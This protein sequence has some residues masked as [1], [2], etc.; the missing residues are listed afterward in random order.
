MTNL[1]NNYKNYHHPLV[2]II[3]LIIASLPTIVWMSDRWFAQGSYYS[4]GVLVPFVSLFLIYQKKEIIKKIPLVESVWGLWLFMLG[5]VIYCLSAV[6]HVYFS[7]AF[8]MLLI[9]SGLILHFYGE[10]VFK[11]LLF[12]LTFL[13]FMIPLPLIVVSF[14]CFKLKIIAAQIATFVLNAI[15]LHAIRLSSIIKMQ[16]CDILVEDSCGGLR[17]LISLMALGSIFAYQLRSSFP[18]KMLFFI[19]TIPIAT[20]T[21]AFRIVFISAIGEMLGTEYT[22]GFLHELSGYLVFGFAFVLLYLVKKL[23]E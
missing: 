23:L 7:S 5:V 19:S 17:S 21:N 2:I 22:Q 18:P 8:A 1:K 12:P 15:G 13:V 16:H 10:K 11:E 6:M 4:H 3:L 9:T 14:I 20:I